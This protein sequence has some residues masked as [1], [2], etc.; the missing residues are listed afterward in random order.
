MQDTVRWA[1]QEA[2][3]AFARIGIEDYLTMDDAYWNGWEY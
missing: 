3:A 1:Q 2:D